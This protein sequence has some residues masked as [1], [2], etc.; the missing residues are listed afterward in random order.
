MKVINKSET[1]DEKWVVG[2]VIE[3]GDHSYTEK[4]HVMVIRVVDISATITLARADDYLDDSTGIKYS[5]VRLDGGFDGDMGAFSSGKWVTGDLFSDMG[6]L[7][8]AFMK[9]C[10]YAKKVPFYGV[11][12][13]PEEN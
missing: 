7:K 10:V 4:K 11:V 3:Y 6:S 12:G 8:E 13:K 5:T 2:D 9:A 1:K